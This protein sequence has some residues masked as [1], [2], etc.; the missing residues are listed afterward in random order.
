[1]SSARGPKRSGGRLSRS[2]PTPP[3]LGWREYLLAEN[4]SSPGHARL[5]QGFL[6]ALA[7]AR[8]RLAV[9]GLAIVLLL[10]L[11]ALLAPLLA[12]RVNRGGEIALS[13][14]LDAQADA[15]TAAYARWFNIDVWAREDGWVLLA[16]RRRR[17][18]G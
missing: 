7:F 15:L 17:D 8:N 16:G 13:G 6:M 9:I 4:P 5:R 3:K 14:I 2:L 18:D 11:T 1:M 12:A 10:I